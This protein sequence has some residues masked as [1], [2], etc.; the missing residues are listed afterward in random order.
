M[1]GKKDTTLQIRISSE[2]KTKLQA[3]ARLQNMDLSEWM[4]NRLSTTTSVLDLE[5][6][7]SNLTR[8]TSHKLT[9]IKNIFHEA[10]IEIW[11]DL[12]SLKPSD[13]D[14]ETLA[15]L[16]SMIEY[17]ADYRDLPRPSWTK[18]VSAL[19]TPYFDT[20]NYKLKMILMLESKVQFKARNI[21]VSFE[22]KGFA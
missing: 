1:S 5:L 6:C 11:E 13:C 9:H 7:Y 17:I 10:P 19:Q 2:L 15:Y 14:H 12:I 20:N 22:D 4:L 3:L 18:N 21:F 16:A 8:E